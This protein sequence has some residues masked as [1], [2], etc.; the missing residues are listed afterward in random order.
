MYT[1]T[2]IAF[3]GLCYSLLMMC[4]CS[5]FI[6]IPFWNH[7]F[8]PCGEWNNFSVYIYA[9]HIRKSIKSADLCEQCMC[10]N[11]TPLYLL[12]PLFYMVL[13]QIL[14]HRLNNNYFPI[15]ITILFGPHCAACL[16]ILAYNI[17]QVLSVTSFW[18]L[19][20]I[21]SHVFHF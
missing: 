6:F 7:I 5:S 2:Y 10:H 14:H 9:S 3:G 8:Y 21:L 18:L 17:L 1:A 11:H 20:D 15:S 12:K 19:F 16:F 13:H 4:L